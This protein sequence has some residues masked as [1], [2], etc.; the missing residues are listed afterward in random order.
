METLDAIDSEYIHFVASIFSLKM[1]TYGQNRNNL[2]TFPKKLRYL[3]IRYPQ[4]TISIVIELNSFN[5]S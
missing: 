1:Q 5:Q 4:P 2:C 3:T